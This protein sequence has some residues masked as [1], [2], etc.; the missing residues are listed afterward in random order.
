MASFPP[1]P[2]IE[3][4]YEIMLEIYTHESARNP[5]DPPSLEYG[6]IDRLTALGRKA[7]EMAVYYHY[8]STGT[9]ASGT[10]GESIL[11]LQEV[12]V[13]LT[14]V[15][16]LQYLNQRLIRFVLR[17]LFIRPQSLGGWTI[18][19]SEA[20]SDVILTTSEMTMRYPYQSHFS[21]RHLT[22]FIR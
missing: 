18:I 12:E 17:V 14:H 15:L 16:M 13:S 8:F 5:A 20:R 6:S 1:L 3:G 22:L 19:I 21:I 11:T 9:S 10:S 7:A 4:D 2:P